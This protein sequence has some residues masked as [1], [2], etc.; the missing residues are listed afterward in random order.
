M[1][2][3]VEDNDPKGE[4]KEAATEAEDDF[5]LIIPSPPIHILPWFCKWHNR[6]LSQQQQ[7]LTDQPHQQIQN[8]DPQT[9]PRFLY[10]VVIIHSFK[11]YRKYQWS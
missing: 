4:H 10:S 2:D 5:Q 8:E 3:Q 6:L 11:T 1:L 9:L 7:L